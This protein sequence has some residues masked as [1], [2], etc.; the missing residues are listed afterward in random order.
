MDGGTLEYAG[1]SLVRRSGTLSAITVKGA[2]DLSTPLATLFSRMASRWSPTARPP[3]DQ[4]D[5]RR[6]DLAMADN[7]TLDNAAFAIGNAATGDAL[8]TNGTL[9]L[10]TGLQLTETAAGARALYPAS[11]W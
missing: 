7:E 11:R 10:G 2:L 6:R 4:P 3:P 9:T 1:T 5:R 8:N